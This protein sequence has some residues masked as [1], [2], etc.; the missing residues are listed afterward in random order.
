MIGV[1]IANLYGCTDS[2]ALNYDSLANVDDGS[3]DYSSYIIET[4]GMSFVPDSIVCHVGD[5]IYFNLDLNHNAVEVSDST[6]N[7]NGT[8]PKI[9][10]FNFG[11]LRF[12]FGIAGRDIVSCLISPEPSVGNIVFVVLC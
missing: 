11:F 7:T 3:C 10:G 4:V 6:W 12:D 1:I 9:D 2:L 5:T 8:N